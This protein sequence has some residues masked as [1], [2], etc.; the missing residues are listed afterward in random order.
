ME[1]I[2]SFRHSVQQFIG[3]V[4]HL[5]L[6]TSHALLSALIIYCVFL[7]LTAW[8]SMFFFSFNK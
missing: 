7:I 3:W 4:Y 2:M 5:V 1:Y 6:I 8:P